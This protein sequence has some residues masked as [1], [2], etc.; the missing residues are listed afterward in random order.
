M[1]VCVK[2]NSRVNREESEYIFIHF[3]NCESLLLFLD[4]SS[5]PF[6]HHSSML[7]V[8]FGSSSKFRKLILKQEAPE[9]IPVQFVSADIDEYAITVLSDCPRDESDATLLTQAI[10]VAKADHILATLP[11][12]TVRHSTQQATASSSS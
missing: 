6:T 3:S 10:A 9:I 8:I 12:S 5:L 2:L 7:P 1:C 4:F 11:D